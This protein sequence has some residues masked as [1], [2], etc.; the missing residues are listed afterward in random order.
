MRA[1]GLTPSF[2]N[3]RG[4]IVDQLGQGVL[5]GVA[6]VGIALLQAAAA[7]QCFDDVGEIALDAADRAALTLPLTVTQG[8]LSIAAAVD[9]HALMLTPALRLRRHA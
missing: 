6:P 3:L 2:E 1:S 4:P 8:A 7:D 9:V 5:E